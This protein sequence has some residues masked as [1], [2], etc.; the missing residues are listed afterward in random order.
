[1]PIPGNLLSATTEAVDPNTS[2][3]V[4]KLNATLLLG[5][6]GRNGVGCL[7]VRSVAAGEMQARTVSSY[8]VTAGTVYQTF[9]DASAAATPE[10]IGIRW[11]NAAGSEISITWSLTTATASASWHR[12][13]VAGAAP[14]GTATAQVVLSSTEAGAAVSHYWENVYL[15]LPV[16][17]TGNLFGFGT[18][19]PEIDA[20]G[21]TALV[22][23]TVSRQAP[24]VS[25]AVDNYVAGGHMVALTAT[26]AGNASMGAVDRPA[27][28][29]GVEYL[30]YA[31]LNPPTTAATSWIELRF[32]DSGGSQVQVTRSTLAPPGT[33]MY[34]QRVSAKAPATAATASVA[35]GIDSA[36]AGQVLRAETVCIVAVTTTP[37]NT[38]VPYADGSFEQGVGAWTTTSGV[39]TLARTTPWGTGADGSYALAATSSTATASVIRSGRYPLTGNTPGQGWRAQILAHIGT[40][41]WGP[42]GLRIRWYDASNADLGTSSTLS[43]ALP[44]SAWYYLYVDGTPPASATQAAIE[45]TL[46]ASTT[47]A[48][49]HVDSVAMWPALPLTSVQAYSADGYIALTLRELPVGEFITVWRGMPDGSRVLVRG[50]YGLI[51]GQAI[52]SDLMV[53][54]DHEAP[55]G[56]AVR[57]YVS[58]TQGSSAPATRTSAVATITLDNAAE[59]WVKDPG[60]PQRNMRV[61]ITAPPDWQRPIDQAAYI[62]KGR[63]N[64]VVLSGRRQGLEGSIAIVTRSDE[65][66]L[67]L[68]LLLDSGNTLLV[69]AA[70]D[71]GVDDMFVSIAEVNEN[72]VSRLAGEQWRTWS[73]PLVEVDRPVTTGVNGSGGRTWQ[74]VVAEFD[75]CADLLPVYATSEALLL[76]RRTG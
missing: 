65:E 18:E 29:P 66:R 10:R 5:G 26:A 72:R 76:D 69:Q 46:S 74:D 14:S 55:I 42:V 73:L 15:G 43:F 1:M 61:L 35:I 9:A 47:S 57:Y 2:G 59:V 40:G 56:I 3:W 71:S 33:G 51:D 38:I 32:Y 7:A 64:K 34:R 49:M 22:N 58:I 11:L 21:W 31:Y 20:S 75:T 17:T 23:G 39:A 70:P 54:E 27:V 16:R 52:T 44:G 8:P 62:V 63:R 45:V 48:A 4:A 37:A 50:A 41:T 24:M 30:A 53:I 36:S 68:H 19:T 13:S 25:W 67:A 6:G 12:V 60:N 28:S